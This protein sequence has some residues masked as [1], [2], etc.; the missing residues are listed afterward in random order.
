MAD[1]EA[2]YEAYKAESA[3]GKV[4]LELPNEFKEETMG[5]LTSVIQFIVTVIREQKIHQLKTRL[6]DSSEKPQLEWI[7]KSYLWYVSACLQW[8]NEFN[9][10]NGQSIWADIRPTNTYV[11]ELMRN[12]KPIGTSYMLTCFDHL[13]K[14]AGLLRMFYSPP[15]YEISTEDKIEQ[16]V[17]QIIKNLGEK[18][19]KSAFGEI[20]PLLPSLTAIIYELFRNTHDWAT[21]D[22]LGNKIEPSVRGLYFRYLKNYPHK[23]KEYTKE[24]E[25]LNKYFS[26]P[27]FKEDSEGKISFIEITVFDSGEGFAGR[28]LGK[29]YT[30][31]MPVNEEVSIIRQCLTKYHTNE[32]G[33]KGINKGFGL[34]RVQQTIDGKGFFSIRSN[35]AH[36]YRDMVKDGYESVDKPENI[37]VFDWTNNSD[38]DFISL[39][40]TKGSV[41]SIILPLETVR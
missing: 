22:R 19:N 41:I 38:T 2:L 35:K 5:V 8:L 12:Y 23:I 31:D 6:K 7:A 18:I 15:E 33:K 24:N 37:K 36:V 25:G 39:Y 21:S 10:Q 4:D 34:D 30:V 17:S 40:N 16:Y 32:E 26:H 9:Y 11:N 29:V 20:I 13:R 14:N 27:I 1:I 28:W 3:N